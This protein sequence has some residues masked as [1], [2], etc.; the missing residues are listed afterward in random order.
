MVLTEK[1][2]IGFISSMIEVSKRSAMIPEM[3]ISQF[4]SRSLI[5]IGDSL[6]DIDFLVLFNT[7]GSV[8]HA[9]HIAVLLPLRFNYGYSNKM[10]ERA[11]TYLEKYQ[12][13]MAG[14]KGTYW[15][16]AQEFA[17]QLRSY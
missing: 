6:R 14:L 13:A 2:Y 8:S 3:I 11:I 16:T 5:F 10:K 4:A 12:H 7:F 1:D 9:K 17:I 15:G